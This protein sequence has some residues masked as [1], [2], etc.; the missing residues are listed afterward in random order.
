MFENDV[1]LKGKGMVNQRKIW[2]N[3][4]EMGCTGLTQEQH[5]LC[6]ATSVQSDWGSEVVWCGCV[7]KAVYWDSF[8]ETDC[9]EN[10]LDTGEGRASQEIRTYCQSYMRPTRAILSEAERNWIESVSLEYLIDRG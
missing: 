6:E 1:Q 9:R 2:Q 7:C 8:T 10:K 3:E 5:P 4:S